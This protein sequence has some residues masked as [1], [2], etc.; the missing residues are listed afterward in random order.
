ML[1]NSRFSPPRSLPGAVGRAVAT[2]GPTLWLASLAGCLPP[3]DADTAAATAFAAAHHDDVARG[4]ELLARYHCGACHEIPG[5]A[6]SRGRVA[7]SLDA[8]G[9]RSYIAGRIA[10]DAATLARW[11]VEPAALVP[12]TLMP[13][14]G[15]SPDDARAMAAYLLT[16][17]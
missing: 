5:V 15:A 10:S 17:R 8:F 14:M 1:R 9:R 13:S 11:I 2:A 7:P 4:R 16:L 12:G 3:R 6:A